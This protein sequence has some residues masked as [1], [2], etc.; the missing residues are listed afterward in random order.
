MSDGLQIQQAIL[1]EAVQ[2]PLA[3]DKEIML[4]RVQGTLFSVFAL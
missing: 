4:V 3:W 2:W 1:P